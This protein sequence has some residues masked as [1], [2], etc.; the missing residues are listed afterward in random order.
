MKLLKNIMNFWRECNG[1]FRFDDCGC[2]CRI[3]C[4]VSIMKGNPIY[5]YKGLTYEVVS[6]NTGQIVKRQ[7]RFRDSGEQ[8]DLD[9]YGEI[10][11][12]DFKEIVDT[13]LNTEPV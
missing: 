12:E 1:I 10:S 5:A 4:S 11:L 2:R 9:M 3:C 8:I 6:N 7:M 13:Y